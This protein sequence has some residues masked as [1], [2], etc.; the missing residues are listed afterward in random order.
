MKSVD[1]VL[2]DLISPGKNPTCR[3]L[4]EA[5][6][7]SAKGEKQNQVR[8]LNDIGR[9]RNVPGSNFFSKQFSFVK[10]PAAKTPAYRMVI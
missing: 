6:A 4:R 5:L 2:P 8:G 7:E 9:A 1:S 3:F 10:F